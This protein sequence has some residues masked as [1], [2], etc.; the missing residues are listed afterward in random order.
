LRK[1]ARSAQLTHPEGSLSAPDTRAIATSRTPGRRILATRLLFGT[2]Y[3]CESI[4]DAGSTENLN[5]ALMKGRDQSGT[6]TFDQSLADLVLS[7]DVAFE[8]AVKI[9]GNPLDLELQ[10]RG[11]R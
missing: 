6:Q 11:S 2:P 1:L 4:L 9:A 10:L 3:V 8:M 5:D 7:G